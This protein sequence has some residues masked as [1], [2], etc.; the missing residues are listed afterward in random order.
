MNWIRRIAPWLLL[1]A[2]LPLVVVSSM[3]VHHETVDIHDDCLQCAG[4]FEAQHHHQNDC[5]YCHFLGL[6]YLGQTAGHLAMLIPSTDTPTL[7]ACEPTV[8]LRHGVSLLR[9]P[10]VV[11][12]SLS[13]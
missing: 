3:H 1:A 7:P 2:Y 5:Q 6:R 11:K 9:A 10:P 8:Q 12:I 4:H 13:F